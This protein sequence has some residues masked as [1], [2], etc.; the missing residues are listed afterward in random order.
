M[1]SDIGVMYLNKY[2]KDFNKILMDMIYPKNNRK[3]SKIVNN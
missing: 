2:L 1:D 3:Y